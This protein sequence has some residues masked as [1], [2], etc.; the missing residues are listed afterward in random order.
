MYTEPTSGSGDEGWKKAMERAAMEGR[1]AY[2]VSK[3]WPVYPN[4]S[5]EETLANAPVR[6]ATDVA[7]PAIMGA[8]DS[9]SAGLVTKGS[10]TALEKG[11]VLPRGA[12]EEARQ[13]AASSPLSYGAGALLGSLIPGLAKGAGMLANKAVSPLMTSAA[14]KAAGYAL[15]GED[16][17]MAAAGTGAALGGAAGQF[18]NMGFTRKDENEADNY[19]FYFYTRAG[20]DPGRFDDFFQHMIDTSRAG[21]VTFCIPT[22]MIALRGRALE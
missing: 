16:N 1:D 22:T 7:G 12:T 4:A 3:E 9:A 14:G 5:L 13:M 18:A 10:L 19:G 8:G 2:R 6:L 20:W 11:G 17:K 15:G 21:E